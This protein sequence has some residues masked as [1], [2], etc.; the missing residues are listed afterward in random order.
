MY[1]MTFTQIQLKVILMVKLQQKIRGFSRVK[2]KDK[3]KLETEKAIA[4]YGSTTITTDEA[5]F[6]ISNIKKNITS[7]YYAVK[8]SSIDCAIHAG[9]NAK[10][11]MLAIRLEIHHLQ[12]FYKPSYGAEEKEQI[13]KINENKL[14]GGHKL[15]SGN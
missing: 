7:V 6:E 11:G 5:L 13:S 15:N 14:H 3:S 9:S 8:E 10:E 12:H 4:E 1:L 2:T